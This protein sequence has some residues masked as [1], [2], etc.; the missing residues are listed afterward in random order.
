[1]ITLEAKIR[2]PR[3]R[4]IVDTVANALLFCEEAGR[5]NCGIA[6]DIG[7]TLQAGQNIAQNIMLADYFGRLVTMH[8]L[9]IRSGIQK[10]SSC[11]AY[12]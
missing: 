6:V 5:K 2:E 7:H 12:A 10:K 8:F 1:M 11:G 3:N 4:C 9:Q